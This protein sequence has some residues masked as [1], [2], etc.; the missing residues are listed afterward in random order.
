LNEGNYCGWADC[1]IRFVFEYRATMDQIASEE[2]SALRRS[3][4]SV[5]PS[6]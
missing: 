2:K 5:T 1:Y 6:C 3:S 4:M